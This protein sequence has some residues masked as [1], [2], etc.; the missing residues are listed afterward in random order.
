MARTGNGVAG[1]LKVT[2]SHVFGR[3]V[4]ISVL[5]DLL[6]ENPALNVELLMT[7]TV[8]DIVEE[9]LDLAIRLARPKDSSLVAK[10]LSTNPRT[11]CAALVYIDQFGP[12]DA[13]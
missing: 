2:C 5:R 7:D 8:M 6:R 1:K 4:L 3:I 11:L 12:Q 9:G 10:Q 13:Q